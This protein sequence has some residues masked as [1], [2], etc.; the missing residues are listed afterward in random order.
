MSDVAKPK[1]MDRALVTKVSKTRF[2]LLHM[3]Q[4]ISLYVCLGCRR[5]HI[6]P[7][8]KVMKDMC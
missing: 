5:P 1:G 3:E 8:R 2:I 6:L 4:I 7:D